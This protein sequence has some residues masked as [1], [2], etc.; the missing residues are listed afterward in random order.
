[1][2][3]FVRVGSRMSRNPPSILK[4]AAAAAAKGEPF[5]CGERAQILKT[6]C[7]RVR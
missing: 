1:L 4:E 3:F 5:G 7:I 6:C 2:G